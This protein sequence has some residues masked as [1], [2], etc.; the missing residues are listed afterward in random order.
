[1]ERVSPYVR[2]YKRMKDVV[3]QEAPRVMHLA[4][5]PQPGTDMRRYNKPT[6]YEL[7]VVF[8]GSDGTPPTNRDI[9]VWPRDERYSV[10]GVSQIR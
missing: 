2:L 7:A 10:Y 8:C 5:G 6:Q 9:V 1:M 3:D 4:I